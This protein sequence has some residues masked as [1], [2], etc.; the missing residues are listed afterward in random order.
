MG[1]FMD[2]QNYNLNS[3]EDHQRF[4]VDVLRLAGIAPDQ[5][6]IALYDR[7]WD[8]IVRH[9]GTTELPAKVLMEEIIYVVWDLCEMENL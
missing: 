3:A 4:M 7:A 9:Y 5:K 6:G 2:L 1:L 8:I